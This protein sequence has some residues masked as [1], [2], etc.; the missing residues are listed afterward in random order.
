MNPSAKQKQT[1]GQGE[2]TGGCRGGRGRGGGKGCEREGWAGSLGV[3]DANYYVRMD[4][5]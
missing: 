4:V 1:H 2:Q 3:V 5:Q